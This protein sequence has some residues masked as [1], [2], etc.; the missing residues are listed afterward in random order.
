MR[1]ISFIKS[2]HSNNEN[3]VNMSK[4]AFVK[5]LSSIGTLRPEQGGALGM[6]APLE[7]QLQL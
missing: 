4:S 7:I 5:I 2:N 6:N 3:R 1:I